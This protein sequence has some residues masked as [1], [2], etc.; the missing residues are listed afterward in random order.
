MTDLVGDAAVAAVRA[1]PGE[2]QVLD[3]DEQQC[4]RQALLDRGPEDLGLAG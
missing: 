4:A 3:P 1:G 2:H